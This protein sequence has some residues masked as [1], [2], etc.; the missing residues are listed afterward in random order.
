[1]ARKFPPELARTVVDYL[2]SGLGPNRVAAAAGV[3]R[4]YVRKV[5]HRLGGVYRPPNTNYSQRYLDRE[6][7]YE[8]ARRHDADESIRA[9]AAAMS[10]SPS[11]VSRELRRNRDPRSSRYQP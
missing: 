5:H 8:I 1:M 7:R 9:I 4:S 2:A 6:E 3:S 10:R 11:T